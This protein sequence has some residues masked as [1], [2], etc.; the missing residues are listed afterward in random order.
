M[1]QTQPFPGKSAIRNLMLTGLLAAGTT[2][3]SQ[4][5]YLKGITIY[6]PTQAYNSYIIFGA[7]DN[8]THLID[9][10]G[11]MCSIQNKW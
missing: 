8:K 6:D 2:A 4:S 3:R 5:V 7:P 11:T 9:I 1:K 10:T